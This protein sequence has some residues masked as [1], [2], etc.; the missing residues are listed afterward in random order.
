[1][2]VNGGDG[3]NTL[4]FCTFE[5]FQGE[6]IFDLIQSTEEIPTKLGPRRE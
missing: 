4:G 5:S 2:A 1:M 6:E 3:R